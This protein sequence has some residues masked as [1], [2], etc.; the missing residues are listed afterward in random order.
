MSRST[1]I[2]SITLIILL[3][4]GMSVACVFTLP[5]KTAITAKAAEEVIYHNYEYILTTLPFPM[6]NISSVDKYEETLSG[7]LEEGKQFKLFNIN[8][9]ERYYIGKRP[10]TRTL[11]TIPL[12]V[13]V[14]YDTGYC[15][16]PRTAE[17]KSVNWRNDTDWTTYEAT[18]NKIYGVMST[19]YNFEDY[20]TTTVAQQ[21]WFE[22]Q[23]LHKLEGL[24]VGVYDPFTRAEIRSNEVQ[25]SSHFEAIECNYETLTERDTAIPL[26]IDDMDNKNSYKEGYEV[27][28]EEGIIIGQENANQGDSGYQL[29]YNTGYEIGKTEGYKEGSYDVNLELSQVTGN[30]I[31]AIT[32]TIMR[33]LNFEVAGIS[34]WLVLSIVGGIL[35]IGLIIKLVY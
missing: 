23:T 25:D 1:K 21:F 33:F 14:N 9:Y 20:P 17:N 27:G 30:T 2:I 29:G 19:N 35:V 26:F 28:K 3:L 34:V 31:G 6:Q 8:L 12:K 32:D 7:I 5:S 13:T 16:Y 10:Y 24:I 22:F 11:G 4:I 18:N 15:F